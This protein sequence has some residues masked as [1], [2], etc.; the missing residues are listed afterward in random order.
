[1]PPPDTPIRNRAAINALMFGTN[2]IS[3]QLITWGTPISVTDHL[4]PN[5]SNSQLNNSEPKAPPM[6]NN[7]LIHEDSSTETRPDVSG[8]SSDSRSGTL[9]DAQPSPSP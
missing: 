8:D 5:T 3:A 7:E 9:G 2:A 6:Q 1:M 4:R